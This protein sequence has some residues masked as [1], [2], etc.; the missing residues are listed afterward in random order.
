MSFGKVK[1]LRDGGRPADRSDGPVLTFVEGIDLVPQRGVVVGARHFFLGVVQI[2]LKGHLSQPNL[3]LDRLVQ[4]LRGVCHVGVVGVPHYP[5]PGPAVLSQGH[6]LHVDVPNCPCGDGKNGR[7]VLEAHHVGQRLKPNLRIA[8]KIVLN[9]RVGIHGR[10]GVLDSQEVALLPALPLTLVGVHHA[11]KA[12]QGPVGLHLAA[13]IH[14]NAHVGL[15]RD[16]VQE[17]LRLELPVLRQVLGHD[18]S[19]L[20]PP[21]GIAKL[22]HDLLGEG[23]PHWGTESNDLR[24]LGLRKSKRGGFSP[25]EHGVPVALMPGE[26]KAEGVVPAQPHAVVVQELFVALPAHRAAVDQHSCVRGVRHD[27]HVL[28]VKGD[29][30][31][32]LL[33]ALAVELELGRVFGIVPPHCGHP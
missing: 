8:N 25:S 14:H 13:V 1:R 9:I 15:V 32:V 12:V 5:R 20:A 28:A 18:V 16:A 21:Q 24:D 4:Q 23:Q 27:E 26:H 6:E 30:C 22:R 3:K 17:E 10:R 11:L 33:H 31:V 2:R 7:R 19:L 29:L